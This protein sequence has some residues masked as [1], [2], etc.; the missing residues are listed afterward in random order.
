[1]DERIKRDGVFAANYI[2]DRLQLFSEIDLSFITESDLNE[3]LLSWIIRKSGNSRQSAFD[4]LNPLILFQHFI[5]VDIEELE[6]VVQGF[7]ERR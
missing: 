2:G 5:A 1:L 6:D 4:V 3:I 7:L